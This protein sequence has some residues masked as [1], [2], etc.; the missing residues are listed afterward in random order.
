M[1]AKHN[2]NK[3]KLKRERNKR[4]ENTAYLEIFRNLEE[5]RMR[6]NCNLND[7]LEREIKCV[8]T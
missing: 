5:G 3:E 2:E 1:K 4:K 7:I 8:T 6:Y